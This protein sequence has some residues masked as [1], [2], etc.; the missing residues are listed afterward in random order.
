MILVQLSRVG[1]ASLPSGVPGWLVGVGMGSVHTFFFRFQKCRMRI[2]KVSNGEQKCRMEKVMI[3]FDRKVSN[4]LIFKSA[5]FS[6]KVLN[7]K[8]MDPTRPC[9]DFGGFPGSEHVGWP[10]EMDPICFRILTMWVSL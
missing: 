6:R 2:S 10:L 7:K 5:E 8:G 4:I 3:S 9:M 1:V